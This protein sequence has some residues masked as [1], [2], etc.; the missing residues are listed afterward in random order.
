MKKTHLLLMFMSF[1]LLGVSQLHAQSN[2]SLLLQEIESLKRKVEQNKPGKSLFL[3]RGYAH[4]GFVRT[5]DQISFDGGSLNPLLVFKQ[6]DRLLFESELEMEL[7]SEG[8]EVNLE[9]ANIS[10][11]LTKTLT[12]RAGKF[13]TP[14]G[15]FVPRLHPAW[16]NKFPTNP[17][18]AGHD[19]L[20]PTA[21]IGVEL[22][23][24]AYMG[25]LKI[26]YSLYG[27]NGPALNN[28]S[29][30]PDEAGK[31]HYGRF[32]DNNK[33]KSI[34]GRL[35]ILPFPNSSLELGFSGMYG[36]VGADSMYENTAATLYAVDASYVKSLSS[37]GS[38]IDFKG[39]YSAAIV[40]DAQY[41]DHDD[42]DELVSFTNKSSTYF[43]QFSIR[44]ALVS[45]PIIR[46]LEF[47]SRYSNIQTPEGSEWEVNQNQWEFS[48]NYWID[49][50][51]V[52]KISYRSIQGEEGHGDEGEEGGHGIGEGNGL[53]IHWAIGF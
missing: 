9:Y 33:G 34:G 24:G 7:A 50:R 6:S 12:L 53:F 32:P 18:G 14:F 30:E 4:S 13:L 29:D 26:N 42:P 41:P 36:L 35:G 52:V 20:L 38:V 45:T 31:L 21:D 8:L 10:Y 48:L 46:N 40:D 28:G 19:G 16:I 25:P 49:W 2:D 3:L 27:V 17:L 47:A 39:Q 5:D 1:I 11:L 15:I 51:T 37:I 43:A 22:R 44:P 23:G